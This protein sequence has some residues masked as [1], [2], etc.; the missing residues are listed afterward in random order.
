MWSDRTPPE[1]LRALV[2][3][4][5]SALPPPGT[6]DAARIEQVEEF[7][8]VAPGFASVTGTRPLLL[9][10]PLAT[11]TYSN[12][13]AV[14][15]GPAG[16]V[17]ISAPAF[18]VLAA[19]LEAWRG[20]AEAIFAGFLSYDLATEIEDVG[21]T[22]PPD[23][24]FPQFYFALYD[25]YL[26]LEGD[27][28]VQVT[29]NA[30]RT[31]PASPRRRLPERPIHGGPLHS[32]PSQSA[33]ETSVERIVATIRAGD[34]FQTNLC[35]RLEAGL[36]PAM[37]W[38]LFQRMRTISPAQYESYFQIDDQRAILSI[39]PELFLRVEAGMVESSPIKGTRPRATDAT[40]DQALS[41]DLLASEKDRAELAMIVDVV[42]NDL[43][44]VCET[45]SV[46]VTQHAALM[47]LPTVHH[48]YSTVRGRLR[49]GLV[50]LL[51]A[52]FPAAS[53]TGAPK[54]EAIRAALREEGQLRGPCMGAIGWISL[55]G[56]MELSVAIRTAFTSDGHVR[57]YVGCGITADSDPH[58]ELIESRHKAAA[59]V[60]ALDRREIT[61]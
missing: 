25:S 38:D 48:L 55:D 32:C 16:A 18:D 60:R 17:E 51:R 14:I 59:F 26:R 53:I 10:N 8:Q 3:K 6:G 44:R 31:P 61:R 40:E 34:I 23:F 20:P 43:G 4:L 54:I 11:I 52:A 21:V 39:S 19:M 5:H 35:R 45:G 1:R 56:N 46:E 47:T 30:W 15:A 36:D 27:R 57:Y 41:S 7:S 13:S 12:G 33:F 42:R 9:H 37:A 29:T 28:W 58:S 22:P 2:K 24:T 49:D 50:D